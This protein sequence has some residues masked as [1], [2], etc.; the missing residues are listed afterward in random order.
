MNPSFPCPIGTNSLIIIDG[1]SYLYRAYH[2]FPLL[3][4]STG[5]PTGAIYCFL[6]ML[7]SLLLQYQSR[8]IAIVFDV[9]SKTF[10]DELFP[11]YKDHRQLM[12]E[13]LAS[14]IAPLHSLLRAM[15][16][17]LLAV[18][19]VEADDV[20]GT[21]AQNAASDGCHVLISTS[22]KD[23]AQL[24]STNINLIH[25]P[26][27]TI[28]GPQEVQLKFGVLPK[29]ISD[30]LALIGD[31]SDN[32]PG[33]PGVGKHTAKVLLHRFDNLNTLYQNLHKVSQ[34][35]VR[36]AKTLAAKLEK[37]R[38]VAFLSYQLATI[39]TDVLLDI[40]YDQLIREK[41]NVEL[42]ELIFHKLEL[43]H[44]LT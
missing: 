34:L 39:K 17:P 12:P 21:I 40:T 33:V 18:S 29:L 3:T 15:G 27:K 42:L 25:T 26:S 11:S 19:G 28:L 32:I 5:Q 13:T 30:Y 10:R 22:D 23:I 36:G 20:I 38:A 37:N 44:Y 1:S 16:I 2:A 14:Q 6:K 9:K 24:V 4:N 8:Y 41:P 31:S 7:N 35:T 43:K